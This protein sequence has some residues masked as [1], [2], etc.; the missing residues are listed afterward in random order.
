MRN[1]ENCRLNGTKLSADFNFDYYG[2]FYM[3]I[4]NKKVRIILAVIIA[5]SLVISTVYMFAK[6][7]FHED[8]LLTYNLANSSKQL[9][10]DGGWNSPEDFNE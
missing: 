8:E 10:V 5:V 1:A 3:K 4:D 6:Q 7:G 9:N 2:E